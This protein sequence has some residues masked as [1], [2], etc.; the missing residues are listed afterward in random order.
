MQ[1]IIDRAKELLAT[2]RS[3]GTWLESRRYCLTIR[4]RLILKL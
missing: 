1:E 2:D 4:N 3:A